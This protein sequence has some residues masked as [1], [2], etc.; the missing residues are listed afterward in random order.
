MRQRSFEITTSP[1]T[2]GSAI[3]MPLGG[4]GSGTLDASRMAEWLARRSPEE[5]DAAAAWRASQ[6]GVELK[7]SSEL[8]FP[9]GGGAYPAVTGCTASGAPEAR[10]AARRD[11]AKL[12]TP[13]APREIEA[14]LV[15]LSVITARRQDDEFGEALRLE[16]YASRL[17][18]YPADVVRAALFDAAWKFWPSWAELHALCER[19]V[20]A[21]CW[22]LRALDMPERAAPRPREPIERRRAVAAEL[23]EEW[24]QFM[25]GGAS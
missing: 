20:L 1:E 9:D 2:P 19:L 21:R 13:A 7:V 5:V 6:H 14:W 25:A 17:R 15:E 8:R 3:G 23:A 18:A 12:M 16:A 22:M 11:I 4:H 10:A 24:H